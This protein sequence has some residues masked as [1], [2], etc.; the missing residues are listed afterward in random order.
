MSRRAVDDGAG[1]TTG[2]TFPLGA[3]TELAHAFADRLAEMNGIRVVFIKGPVANAHVLRDAKPS[4]DVDVMVDPSAIDD[5]IRSLISVGWHERPASFAQRS[6]ASHSRSFIN[7]SWPCDID[8]HVTFPGFLASP[9]DCFEELWARR[10]TVSVAG[11]EIPGADLSASI[12]IGA[13]HALRSPES[14]AHRSELEV[15]VER[16]SGRLDAV[17]LSELVELAGTLGAVEPVRPALRLLGL[18]VAPTRPSPR[19]LAEWRLQTQ[20]ANRSGSWLA[21]IHAAP[22]LRKPGLVVR[23]LIPSRRDLLIEH[24]GLANSPGSLLV[25]RVR[26]LG[27]A[28]RFLPRA[29]GEFR[30]QRAWSGAEASPAIEPV[31]RADPSSVSPTP[32]RVPLPAAPSTPLRTPACTPEADPAGSD[33]ERLR[34]AV[35]VASTTARDDGMFVLGLR[36]LTDARPIHLNAVAALVWQL[37]A[38]PL[39]IDGLVSATAEEFGI[40]DEAV[41]ADLELLIAQLHA[42]GLIAGAADVILSPGDR[43]TVGCVIPTH[44]RDESMLTALGSV[45][46]QTYRPERIV[47]VDD[48]GSEETR[49][50]VEGVSRIDE[51]V[52]YCDAADLPRKAAGASRNAGAAELTSDLLAFLDDDDTWHPEFLEAAIAELE[53]SNAD[54]VVTWGSLRRGE[55]VLD[56]NWQAET[57]F[58]AGQILADNPGVTGSNFVV[59]RSAFTAVGGFDAGLWV[60]NDLDFF[61]RFLDAG[62]PYSVVRRDLVHQVSTGGDHLSSR[63]ERRARGIEA[64]LTKYDSRVTVRQRRALVRSIHLARLFRDQSRGRRIVHLAG[65]ISNSSASD[66]IGALRR[67]LTKAPSYN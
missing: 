7:S 48:T 4:A 3:A 1:T 52:L 64:Y 49:A 34:R 37:I 62:Y 8:V 32:P 59:R 35:P 50:A 54:L 56:H 14:A 60:Y 19:A 39:T 27:R 41:R 51:T 43:L 61:V 13:L 57:G 25:A 44:N 36:S 20:Q 6:L 40:T 28:V 16:C 65:A 15:L 21:A 58:T 10:T 46:G 67:R 9:Q 47:V 17:Q 24:P 11:R 66:S 33:D 22:L 5:Y 31:P 45:R 26:R 30:A 42:R 18:D 12:L 63:S 2:S 55:L 38:E 23:A 29:L 53:R